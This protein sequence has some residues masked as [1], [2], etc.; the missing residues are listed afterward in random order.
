MTPLKSYA[1]Y[2][3]HDTFFFITRIIGQEKSQY[4]DQIINGYV[5]SYNKNLI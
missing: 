4:N 5:L 2:K 1:K 3:D